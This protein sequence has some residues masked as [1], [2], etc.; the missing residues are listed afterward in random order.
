M[1]LVLIVDDEAA[2]RDV[3]GRAIRQEGHDVIAAES[4][5]AALAAMAARAADVVFTDIQMPGRDGRWLALELRKRYPSTAVVLATSVTDLEP[6]TT[7]RFGVLSYLVKPFDL[8]AVREALKT[9]VA[10]R[11]ERA[12]AGPEEPH[13]DQLEA[14]LDSLEIL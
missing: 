8:D 12:V 7:L 6:S 2:V 1:A 11:E 4:S 13:H 9:A 5:D 3:L 14:W 10:W